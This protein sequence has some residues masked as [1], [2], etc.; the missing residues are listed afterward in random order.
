MEDTQMIFSKLP[1]DIIQHILLY[2]EHFKMRKGKLVS[3]IPKSDDRY[4]ILSFIT[5][6]LRYVSDFSSK[7]L[8][9]YHFNNLYN[10]K[11]REYPNNDTIDVE[12]KES[13]HIHYSIWIGR[14]YPKSFISTKPQPFLIENSDYHWRYIH[15]KYIR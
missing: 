15:H 7:K 5:L 3:I 2:D 6:T 10:Y 4:K 11:E 12:I 9:R 13:N 1:I 8:Y 14:Q